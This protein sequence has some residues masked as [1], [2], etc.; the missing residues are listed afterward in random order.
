MTT[1]RTTGGVDREMLVS[2]PVS[3]DSIYETV[4]R[5][6]LLTLEGASGVH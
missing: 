2:A 6:E 3:Y 4:A 1:E 5:M